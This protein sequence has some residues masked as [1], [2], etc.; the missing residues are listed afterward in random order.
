MKSNSKR[1]LNSKTNEK[2]Q[3]IQNTIIN[4]EKDSK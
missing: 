3:N 2:F 4:L 1:T